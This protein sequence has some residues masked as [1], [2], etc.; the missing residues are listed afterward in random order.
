MDET[1]DDALEFADPEDQVYYHDAQEAC[2]KDLYRGPLDILNDIEKCR[3]NNVAMIRDI[4]DALC[5]G[6][7]FEGEINVD[8]AFYRFKELDH[9]INKI[10]PTCVYIMVSVWMLLKKINNQS[11]ISKFWY[12]IDGYE[13][14]MENMI[15]IVKRLWEPAVRY[16]KVPIITVVNDILSQYSNEKRG[17]VII[18]SYDITEPVR[19]D[20]HLFRCALDDVLSN[21]LK[22][23]SGEI[24]LVLTNDYLDVQ[25]TGHK[26]QECDN[27]LY[28]FDSNESKKYGDMLSYSR[29]M[30]LRAGGDMSCMLYGRRTVFRFNF[31]VTKTAR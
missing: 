4:L 11:E 15:R 25:D 14:F 28:N 18:S 1:I 29:L 16:Q 30:M 9:K 20:V 21:V 31:E 6:P 22:Y 2:N 5:E 10:L 7:A 8:R 13:H 27:V 12:Q 3:V 17:R 19:L 23:S 26:L 24:E